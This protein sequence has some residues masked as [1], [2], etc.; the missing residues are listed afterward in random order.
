MSARSVRQR[1]S[2]ISLLIILSLFLPAGSPPALAQPPQV[3]VSQT[4]RSSP[5]MFI[6]NVGQFDPATGSGQAGPRFLVR[7]G[8]GTLWLAE[9]AQRMTITAREARS[10]GVPTTLNRVPQNETMAGQQLLWGPATLITS[11][12]D[13]PQIAVGSDGKVCASWRYGSSIN[14]AATYIR[15]SA[16]GGQTF[17][18][19][20]LAAQGTGWPHALLATGSDTYHTAWSNGGVFIVRSTDGGTTF[21][22]PMS[23]DDAS[24]TSYNYEMR[25]ALAKDVAGKIYAVWSYYKT[26]CCPYPEGVF[27]ARSTD[28]GASFGPMT[29]VDDIPN[30]SGSRGGHGYLLCRLP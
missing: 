12:A 26:I 10:A 4:L 14:P 22:S 5:V 21:G 20:A 19:T 8:V 2:C 1:V 27:L 16:D 3:A 28:G 9:D 7:G 23:I 13:F 18:H 15:C 30:S 29:R 17:G 24:G 11:T 25:P 6:E